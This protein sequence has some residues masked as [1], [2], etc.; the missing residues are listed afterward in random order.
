MRLTTKTCK[1]ENC[2]RP[3]KFG[4]TDCRLCSLLKAASK[5]EDKEMVE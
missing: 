4:K 2:D 1:R 5:E 3:V